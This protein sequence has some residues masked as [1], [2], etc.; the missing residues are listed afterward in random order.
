MVPGNQLN[1][2]KVNRKFV[3]IYLHYSQNQ[4]VYPII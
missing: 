3:S 2:V 1:V 4:F